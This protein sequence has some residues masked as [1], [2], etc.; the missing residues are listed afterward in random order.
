V[1]TYGPEIIDL[2]LQELQPDQICAELGLC[3]SK[4][5]KRKHSKTAITTITTILK[6][7]I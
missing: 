4:P 6:D 5:M 3:S 2:L 1:E 7:V